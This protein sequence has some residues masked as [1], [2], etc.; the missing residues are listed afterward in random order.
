MKRLGRFV[1]VALAATVV[2][3]GGGILQAGGWDNFKLRHFAL[4]QIFHDQSQELD[5]L[6]KQDIDLEATSRIELAA[7]L[8]GDAFNSMRPVALN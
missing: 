5:D 6:R 4:A 7:R 2:A 8:N 1:L 3:I